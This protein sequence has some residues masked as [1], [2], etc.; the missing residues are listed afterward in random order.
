[1]SKKAV[2]LGVVMMLSGSATAQAGSAVDQLLGQYA[3]L[4]AGPF[5]A[6]A[7]ERIWRSTYGEENPPRQCA[8]CHTPDPRQVGKHARTAKAIE[9]LAPSVAPQRMSDARKVSKWLLRNC[10][11]TLGRE[12]T[13]Q[14]RGDLLA[15]LRGL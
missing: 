15:Y 13:P 7:G 11:W 2:F 4:G 10:K 1:M 9:P 14:E 8:S 5:D 12:C 6:R 3:E